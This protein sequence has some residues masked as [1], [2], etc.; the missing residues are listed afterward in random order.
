MLQ[1]IGA[2]SMEVDFP[3]IA[4]NAL[5]GIYRNKQTHAFAEG[6]LC[7]VLVEWQSPELSLFSKAFSEVFGT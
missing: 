2:K 4:F 3:V 5:L 7:G 6:D 1:L